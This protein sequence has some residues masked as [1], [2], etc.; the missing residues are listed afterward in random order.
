MPLLI[1]W[2]EIAWRLGLAFVAALLVGLNRGERGEAAG[3]RTTILVCLAAAVAMVQANLLLVTEGRTGSSFA[4]LDLMRLPLGILTGMG[5]IGAGAVLKRGNLVLGVTTAASL[6][7]TTVM[8]LCF[9]GGQ[10]TLGLAC[11]VFAIVILWPLKWLES[12]VPHERRATLAVAAAADGLGQ[13]TIERMIRDA[14]AEPIACAVCY[15]PQERL[16]RY[17]FVVR[18]RDRRNAVAVPPFVE[19]LAREAALRELRWLPDSV[20][21]NVTEAARSR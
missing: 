20:T 2:P 6:W 13:E 21:S 7:F 14:R 17:E 5:F 8:G 11:M 18:W 10:T 1:G 19:A 3:L 15:E 12:L 9:G 4:V 16:R